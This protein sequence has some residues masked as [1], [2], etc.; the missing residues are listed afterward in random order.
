VRLLADARLRSLSGLGAELLRDALGYGY[1]A[2]STLLVFVV[3]GFLLGRKEDALA[4]AALTDSLTGL[5]NQGYFRQR[6]TEEVARAARY[7]IPLSLILIDVDHFKQVNDRLGHA[8]GDAL[9]RRIANIIAAGCRRTDYQGVR[10]GGDEFAIILPH[11]PASAAEQLAERLRQTVAASTD[12]TLSIGVAD[13]DLCACADTP[14]LDRNADRAL[15]A[16][17]AA[18]RNRVTLCDRDATERNAHV[19]S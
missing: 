5:F 1:L 2:I 10:R 13:L 12:V 11:T 19:A 9:L 14:T 17:K 15:Y 16:A 7:G 8:A 4:A 18:G 6:L 3:L